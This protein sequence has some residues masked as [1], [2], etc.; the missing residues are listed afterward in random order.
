MG[1]AASSTLY[2]IFPGELEVGRSGPDEQEWPN[3]PRE[4]I[5]QCDNLSL[6]FGFIVS[7]KLEFC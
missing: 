4:V 5:I 1:Q 3:R 6:L 2:I 7:N